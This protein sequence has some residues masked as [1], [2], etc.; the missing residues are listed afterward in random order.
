MRIAFERFVALTATLAGV[1]SAVTACGSDPMSPHPASGGSTNS[2]GSSGKGGKGG[3]A[4]TAGRSTGVGGAGGGR[5]GAG[6][7]S[8]KSTGGDAGADTGGSAG[9]GG[10]AGVGGT[11]VGKGGAGGSAGVGGTLGQA[12]EEA[13]GMG[14]E[15]GEDA[16]GGAGG[17]PNDTCLGDVGIQDCST[18]GLPADECNTGR[19]QIWRSCTYGAELLR[20]GV[21]AGLGACLQSIVD[22]SCTVE[23]DEAT[24][25]CETAAAADACPTAEAVDACANGV[26]LPGG[27]TVPS[28]LVACT[29]GTLTLESCTGLLNAVTTLREDALREV[30]KCS[31]PAGEYVGVVTA[32]TCAERLHQCVFPRSAF[33]PW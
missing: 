27:G 30:V 31:D 33:Y 17:A 9:S 10:T 22:D 4:G 5:A 2:G 8:G 6:G 1:G 11:N 28:P 14:G 32:A 7:S 19:N 15:G 16:E 26:A 21:V 20:P 3:G 12:G 13:G 29:D 24:Y 25:G 18:L 23:A